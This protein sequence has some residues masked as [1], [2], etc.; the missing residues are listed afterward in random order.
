MTVYLTDFE[1]KVAEDYGTA[2]YAWAMEHGLQDMR[3]DPTKTSLQLNQDSAKGEVGFCKLQNVFYNFQLDGP[4]RVDVRVGDKIIDIKWTDNPNYNLAVCGHITRDDAA[5]YF[6][7][8]RGPADG[9]MEYA[10]HISR[11]DFYDNCT[12]MTGYDGR[13]FWLLNASCL[14]KGLIPIL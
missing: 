3:K 5:D 14:N 2:V 9:V 10:G 8:M 13:P 7:L 6:V 1:K 11:D 4:S 12:T